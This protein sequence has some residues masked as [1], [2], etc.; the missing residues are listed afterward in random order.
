MLYGDESSKG[1]GAV[2]TDI[3][4]AK[5]L[6]RVEPSAS[7]I[8]SQRARTL[9]AEGRDIIAL[10]AGEPDF[11]TPEHVIEAAFDAARRGETRYTNAAGTPALKA[12]VIEKF[13]RE[14][15]LDFADDEVMT[16]NGGKQILYN[17]MLSPIEEGDEAIIPAPY[18]IAYVDLVMLAGG[19]PVIVKCP[20]EN[21]FKLT[22][23]ALEAAI[24]P[25][26]RWLIINSPSNPSGAVYSAQE[27][28]E[29]ADVLVR[30]PHVA[31][32]SDDMY[33][34]I[35]YDGATFATIAKVAPELKDRTITVNGVSK[36]YA[37]TG[38]RIGYC[39]GPAPLI[40]QMVKLQQ[41]TTGSTCSVAQAAA[42]AAI[43]GPQD[44]VKPRTESFRERRDLVVSM[45]NQ[46]HGLSCPVPA[47]AFYVFPS[48]ADLIGKKTPD[49]KVIENDT[50]L[51]MYFLESEGVAV[52]QGAAYG[53]SP[54][55]RISFAASEDD[56]IQACERIQRACAELR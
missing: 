39:G 43:T 53:L 27:L 32:L 35:L 18:W 8:A 10:S 49:G 11:A 12:A 34:H 48:C 21:D 9:K 4:I 3:K 31:V 24:T 13:K 28:R 38:W 15:D 23:D 55:F 26:T 2:M 1:G 51:V 54:F 40:K 17:A 33:E 7:S 5:N 14:N 6:L 56:L 37:M 44:F 50:D 45:I 29:I 16:G 36:V 19:T 47:G 52:V 46:A 41:Q 42:V 20:V 25:R 22:A 30:H